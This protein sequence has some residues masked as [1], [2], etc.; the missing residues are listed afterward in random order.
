MKISNDELIRETAKRL[1]LPYQQV[2]SVMV[3][4][5][6]ILKKMLQYPEDYFY[7]GIRIKNFCKFS[8]NPGKVLRNYLFLLDKGEPIK[9]ANQLKI[10]LYNKILLKYNV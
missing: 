10:H 1:N 3:H 2:R 5:F 4:F 9:T 7:R 8:I 6:R